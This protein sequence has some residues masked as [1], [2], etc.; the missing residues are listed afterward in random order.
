MIEMDFR[1]RFTLM[2]D[3]DDERGGASY[4]ARLNHVIVKAL[5]AEGVRIKPNVGGATEL[6][7]STDVHRIEYVS[8]E[9]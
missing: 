4:A 6:L 9:E 3:N 5:Q 1:T 7:I 2:F 8:Y